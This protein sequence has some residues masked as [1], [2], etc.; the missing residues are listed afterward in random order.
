MS[1]N[2]TFSLADKR[3]LVTG[4]SGHLGSTLV[5]W[6][7]ADGAFVYLLDH[8]LDQLHAVRDS[9][10]GTGLMNPRFSQST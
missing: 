5:R 6:L 2:K 9:V 7:V 4:A 8:D 1:H 10:A 3:V